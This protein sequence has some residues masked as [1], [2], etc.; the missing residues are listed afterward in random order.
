MLKL[1]PPLILSASLLCQGPD[2]VPVVVQTF[3]STPTTP[4]PTLDNWT[5]NIFRPGVFTIL[6][7]GPEVGSNGVLKHGV[8]AADQQPPSTTG[9]DRNQ[10]GM[11][12]ALDLRGPAQLVSIRLFVPAA[13][14]TEEREAS[15]ATEGLVLDGNTPIVWAEPRLTFRN[16][17]GHAPGFY[18]FDQTTGLDAR[19]VPVTEFDRWYTLGIRLRAGLVSYYIDGQIVY[20]YLDDEYIQ[21]TGI[22]ANKLNAGIVSVR[23]VGVD[24]EVYWDDYYG[25]GDF[26][27]DGL[28]DRSEDLGPTSP[29]VADGDADALLDG[30]E[31][32]A[33]SN[34]LVPDSDGDGLLDGEEVNVK[35]TDPTRFDTDG[36]MVSDRLDDRPLVRGVSP[37]FL[38]MSIRDVSVA[39]AAT[40][41]TDFVGNSNGAKRSSR[42]RISNRLQDAASRLEKRQLPQADGKLLDAQD[43][44]VALMLPGAARDEFRADIEFLRTLLAYEMA[45]NGAAA[46]ERIE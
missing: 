8:L 21:G 40:P 10:Q 12:S 14:S 45:P 29:T 23:N 20:Q 19:Y 46:S 5:Q 31:L 2:Y 7:T 3:S 33:G 26:D 28:D 1:L 9:I 17:A 30:A 37:A 13:W 35:G 16:D 11:R 4:V 18:C 42:N 6:P 15:L 38:A 41:L 24:Q 27:S 36:D 22:R 25:A 32:D 43:Y 34:P 39:V 44:V